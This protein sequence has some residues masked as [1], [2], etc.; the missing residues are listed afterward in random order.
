MIASGSGYTCAWLLG[1]HHDQ[2]ARTEGGKGQH[3]LWWQVWVSNPSAAFITRLILDMA[4][5]ALGL[6]FLICYVEIQI[7]IL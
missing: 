5:N 4:P 7:L 1:V 3:G 6:S 2:P